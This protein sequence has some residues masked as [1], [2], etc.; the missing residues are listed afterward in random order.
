M[1]EALEDTWSTS[2]CSTC[3]STVSTLAHSS[4]TGIGIAQDAVERGWFTEDCSMCRG[5]VDFQRALALAQQIA[6]GM[7][8]LHANNIVHGVRGGLRSSAFVRACSEGWTLLCTACLAVRAF[9]VAE[10]VQPV[11][12]AKV[13]NAP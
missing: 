3:C 11:S 7:A 12:N 6:E 4:Q 13:S 10:V 8:F 1:K 2:E 9:S 5:V